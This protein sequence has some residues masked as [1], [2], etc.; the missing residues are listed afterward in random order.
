MRLTLLHDRIEWRLSHSGSTDGLWV[1][2]FTRDDAATFSRVEEALRLIKQYD[3]LWY[4]RL[5]CY[6]D[7]IWVRLLHGN[8]AQFENSLKACE[9]DERFVLAETT[10]P[11]QIATVIVHEAT[12]A[13]LMRCGIGSE[14]DMRHAWRPSVLDASL[15]SPQSFPMAG[16]YV[17][18]LK[19]V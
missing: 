14:E 11:E 8:T 2:C 1:G 5:G 3:P 6:L 12:H 15:R 16:R 4:G 13:R 10:G 19:P 9:L 17:S 7:R 18:T